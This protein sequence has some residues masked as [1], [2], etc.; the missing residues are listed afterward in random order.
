MLCDCKES[1]FYFLKTT[2]ENGKI[3]K[4][5]IYK[6]N[7]STEDNKKKKRCDF[8]KE[9]TYFVGDIEEKT[10]NKSFAESKK[11]TID[12][13]KDLKDSIERIKIAQNNNFQY[14][15]YMNKILYLSYHLNIP[16]YI[17]EK[18]T[19]EE[20]NE[21]AMYYINN[22]I[23]KK[24]FSPPVLPVVLIEGFE[25]LLKVKEKIKPKLKMKKMKKNSKIINSI[26]NRLIT[27]GTMFEKE[28]TECELDF[29][30]DNE[31]S[32]IEDEDFNYNS[33]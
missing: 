18:E 20:Y 9:D 5:N 7:R 17:P 12:Y 8:Y 19:I 4:K 2:N 28:N 24:K 31:E 32:D 29:E 15:R 22:P 13:L 25:E 6:C 11:E 33:D 26:S 16:P 3:V 30:P 27:G 14:D 23:P 10:V 21:K 1:A